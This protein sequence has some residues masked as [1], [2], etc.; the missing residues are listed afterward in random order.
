MARC[1]VRAS[2]SCVV[3]RHTVPLSISWMGRGSRDLGCGST[4]RGAAQSSPRRDGNAGRGLGVAF[5]VWDTHCGAST[6]L[7]EQR[8]PWRFCLYTS[9]WHNARRN[10]PSPGRVSV[11]C[12]PALRLTVMWCTVP[13]V[14][15]LDRTVATE[16]LDLRLVVV[17]CSMLLSTCLA[18]ERR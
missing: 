4:A 8:G 7:V 2:I 11:G 14:H 3:V 15:I 18:W 16:V 12:C 17:R 13:L 10:R 6:S 5:Q 9:R 1:A